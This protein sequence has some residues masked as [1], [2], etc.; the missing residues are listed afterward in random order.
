MPCGRATAEFEPFADQRAFLAS[1]PGIEPG[2]AE[3]IA[4]EATGTEDDDEALRYFE[5][6]L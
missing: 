5:E 4:T 1:V 6:D 3:M 2:A